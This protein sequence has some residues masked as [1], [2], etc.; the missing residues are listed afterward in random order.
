MPGEGQ[1][2]DA[3]KLTTKSLL[4]K[5]LISKLGRHNII[6]IYMRFTYVY[7]ND[8][9]GICRFRVYRMTS[10]VLVLI[11]LGATRSSEN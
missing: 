8:L 1:C 11:G 3:E 6:Y 2:R 7:M 4:S 9:Y 5:I 10:G